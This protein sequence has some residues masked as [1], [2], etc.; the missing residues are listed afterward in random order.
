MNKPERYEDIEIMDNC[1]EDTIVLSS[2]YLAPIEYY[3]HV[4]GAKKILLE[5]NDNFQKQT[6][7]NRCSIVGANGVMQLNIPI[8]KSEQKKV[9]MRDV[10]ISD[11]GNWQHLHWNAIISAYN[12]SPFF[13]YYEDDFRYFYEKKFAFLHDLNEGL[14][15]LV[16]KL[17]YINTEVEY[18]NSYIKQMGPGFCDLRNS[19]HPKRESGYQ[20][21]PYWQVFDQK[22]G[23]APNLSIIDL[24]FNK[25]N[26]ARMFL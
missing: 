20:A 12:S 16:F 1:D 25:G 18:T 3:S 15:E 14:R 5:V 7:R 26:E 24:L 17:L 4:Y 10:R 23:F 19:I 11:H 2:F 13:E 21:T 9:L 8:E 6:Y 22:H